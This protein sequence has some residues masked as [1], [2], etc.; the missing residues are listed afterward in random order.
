MKTKNWSFIVLGLY[1]VINIVLVMGISYFALTEKGD[2]FDP[3]DFYGLAFVVA[4]IMLICQVILFDVKVEAE[5][6]RPVA[7]RKITTTSIFLSLLMAI[8]TLLALLTL[9][10]VTLGENRGNPVASS[11]G[12]FFF[13]IIFVFAGSWVFWAYIFLGM[14]KKHLPG[15]FISN[16]MQ[17][18][19]VGSVLELLIA[20][21]SHIIM[22]NRG[23]CCAPVF[24]FMGIITGTT[25]LLFA[26]GPG[27]IFLYL[28]RMRAKQPRS[29]SKEGLID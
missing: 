23:D 16:A 14:G 20:I 22:R 18:L 26:F 15:K 28:N 19:M 11:E 6:K 2:R 24:S 25:V 3:A 8:I 7:R 13:S 21:P 29:K 9:L 12:I 5:E 17:T 27:I 1:L 10:F 4:I